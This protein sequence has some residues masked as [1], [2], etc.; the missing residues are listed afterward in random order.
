MPE[1]SQNNV[2]TARAELLAA[3]KLALIAAGFS[4][5][6]ALQ[7]VLADIE[8]G[9]TELGLATDPSIVN[10]TGLVP[11][12]DSSALVG[13]WSIDPLLN[14][15][16]VSLLH[17]TEFVRLASTSV[18]LSLNTEGPD[19]MTVEFLRGNVMEAVSE[20]MVFT[21]GEANFEFIGGLRGT[22]RFRITGSHDGDELEVIFHFRFRSQ[23]IFN[24]SPTNRQ[25]Q[26]V[27][28]RL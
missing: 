7:I 2:L 24:S 26:R 8:A 27:L 9:L 5:Q 4:E 14:V 15:E 19:R 1:D 25:I 10:A 28:T 16:R 18:R 17:P 21:E 12:F 3:K 22:E 6:E 23:N 20:G 11:Q 13:T